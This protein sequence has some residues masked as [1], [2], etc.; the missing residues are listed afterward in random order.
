MRVIHDNLDSFCLVQLTWYLGVYAYEHVPVY[1]LIGLIFSIQTVCWSLPILN[2][3]L[4]NIVFN[5]PWWLQTFWKILTSVHIFALESSF[6]SSFLPHLPGA[7]C[8]FKPMYNSYV[9]AFWRNKCE[10]IPFFI[11]LLILIVMVLTVIKK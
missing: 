6:I 4:E 9:P 7:S 3:Y 8:H 1:S 5:L 10:R 2:L 11:F